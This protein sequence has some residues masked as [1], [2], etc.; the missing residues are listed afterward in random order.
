MHVDILMAKTDQMKRFVT[1]ANMYNCKNVHST[2]ILNV[3]CMI[4]YMCI[5]AKHE[6]ITP[7]DKV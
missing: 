2:V 1:V 6:K 5:T 7:G 4:Y 3:F